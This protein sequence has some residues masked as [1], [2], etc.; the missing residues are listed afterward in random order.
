M[1]LAFDVLIS[2][3]VPSFHNRETRGEPQKNEPSTNL[4]VTVL[5]DKFGLLPSFFGSSPLF[6]LCVTAMGAL[7]VLS[8]NAPSTSRD[9][10]TSARPLVVDPVRWIK[11]SIGAFG[12]EMLSLLLV[13]LASRS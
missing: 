6:R 5:N 9:N 10:E 11:L 13:V 12:T 8:L 1:F 4:L 3:V 2:I 7:L